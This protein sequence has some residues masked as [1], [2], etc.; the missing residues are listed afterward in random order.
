MERTS[1]VVEALARIAEEPV[2]TSR[3]AALAAGFIAL[4][5]SSAT[6][7]AITAPRI[8]TRASAGDPPHPAL[9]VHS[10]VDLETL[11]DGE[12]EAEIVL[13]LRSGQDTVAAVALVAGKLGRTDPATANY[14]RVAAAIV[15]SDL[16]VARAASAHRHDLRSPLTVIM[17]WC[18]FLTETADEA[19]IAT[20]QTILRQAVRLNGIIDDFAAPPL[21][22]TEAPAERL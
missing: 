18:E 13:G 8:V 22:V 20:A 14:I 15:G 11:I 9:E 12:T 10:P 6:V 16:R 2:V 21:G 4:G 7:G 19:T 5:W 1:V 3:I 17:G